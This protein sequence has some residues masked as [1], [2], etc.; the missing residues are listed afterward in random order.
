MALTY[1]QDLSWDEIWKRWKED[2]EEVWR[3]YY[4]ER[5]C[6]NWEQWRGELIEKYRLELFHWKLYTIEYSEDVTYFFIGPWKGWRT[7]YG[8]REQSRFADIVCYEGFIGSQTEEKL[9]FMMKSFPQDVRFLG[10]RYAEQI[11]VFEGSHRAS[12]VALAM[13]E[14]KSIDSTLTIGLADVSKETW[15]YYFTLNRMKLTSPAFNHQGL[16][17]SKY[18][19][20]GEGVSPPLVFEEVP[21]GTVS[22]ALIMEDPD[23]PTSIR[24]DGMWDHWVV[25]D[26]P[27]YTKGIEE[28]AHPPGIVG[29]STHDENTYGGPCPPDKEHR[30]YFYLY[31]LDTKLDLPAQ[32]TKDDLRTAMEGHVINHAEL[33]GRY[34]RN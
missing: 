12:V 29:I 30:Y 17:P 9:H 1:L 20:D 5:G 34:K 32:S 18:T 15:N 11:M 4:T 24:P 28:G 19:C 2:E 8:K 3:D 13:K 26:M 6:A 22:L 7:F 27:A 33:M 31:A 10:I 21:E 25:W 14:G 16:I 23:V